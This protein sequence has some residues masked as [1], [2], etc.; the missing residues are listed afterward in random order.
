M[1]AWRRIEPRFVSAANRSCPPR[2]RLT[3]E[4]APLSTWYAR[5]LRPN[6]AASM[7]F[8]AP[9]PFSDPPGYHSFECAQCHPQGA[10]RI[11]SSA[12]GGVS[13]RINLASIVSRRPT[14]RASGAGQQRRAATLFD[15]PLH[16]LVRR[17]G[18]RLEEG[19]DTTTGVPKR[20]YFNL[21]TADTIVEMIVDTREMHAPY[22]FRPGVQRWCTN[23][24]FNAQK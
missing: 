17:H 7:C 13:S 5:F 18:R 22:A 4:K 24:R 11:T 8:A 19:P 6:I 1:K 3:F 12:R 16:A 15:G 21:A 14:R 10:H 23:T 20:K 9:T 2:V